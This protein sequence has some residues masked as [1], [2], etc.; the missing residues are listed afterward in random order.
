M[1]LGLS[2]E[3]FAQLLG[4]SWQTV[5]RWE[6][7]LAKP[8]PIM[9]LKI[10][11]LQMQTRTPRK[12]PAS[13]PPKRAIP[14]VASQNNGQ[15][16]VEIGLGGLFKGIGS[17]FELLSKMA[18]EGK[19]EATEWRMVKGVGNSLTGVYGFS[20]RMGLEGM[21]VIQKFGNIDET[22]SGPMVRD[23]REP[24]VDV[25][26][27]GD[28]LLVAVELPGVDEKDIKLGLESDTLE[29]AASTNSRKYHMSLQ[30][31]S[32]VDPHSLATSYRN[33]I[34]ELKLAKKL[35][36]DPN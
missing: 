28:N 24:L 2:Q 31:R 6:G 17:F 21:P 27:R 25:L 20:V 18:R 4:V 19:E 23:T 16:S 34:L 22:D 11:E 35:S 33:G 26:D 9:S 14:M 1:R 3:R 7:G 8:L 5:R 30:L 29:L 10:Q 13:I 36:Q 12:A 15:A 32:T